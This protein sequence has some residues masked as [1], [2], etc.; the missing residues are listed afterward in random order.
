MGLTTRSCTATLKCDEHV[1]TAA[2]YTNFVSTPKSIQRKSAACSAR[3]GQGYIAQPECI[4]AW[5]GWVASQYYVGSQM[6][7]ADS[8]VINRVGQPN[9]YSC[10]A[11]FYRSGNV[12]AFA[13]SPDGSWVN[14]S[15]L[16]AT[17]NHPANVLVN[18][19]GTLSTLTTSESSGAGTGRSQAGDV[20]PDVYV[21]VA[22]SAQLGA[23]P[24]N[25]YN[26]NGFKVALADPTYAVVNIQME[27]S[28]QLDG[29][30]VVLKST[31]GVWSVLDVGTEFV[32]CDK[33]PPVV[34]AS[35]FP[36]SEGCPTTSQPAQTSVT[37][38][39]SGT[40]PPFKAAPSVVNIG[41]DTHLRGLRWQD[42]GQPTATAVGL[43]LQNDCV[44]DCA[45]GTTK[46]VTV[47]ITVSSIGPCR[48]PANPAI[49]VSTVAQS[50]VYRVLAFKDLPPLSVANGF[51]CSYSATG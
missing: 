26:L 42:W 32:G 3:Y 16:A 33:V 14:T 2:D 10:G 37:M 19:D 1:M 28:C 18:S 9:S 6:G 45:E 23:V 34:Y 51:L 48:A 25:C 8:A 17:G 20:P 31:N 46:W 40:G 29:G 15:T 27:S 50:S 7:T 35:L 49:S 12:V 43:S 5:N 44:P 36:G 47:R 11:F 22:R 24:S 38:P 39:T 4:L 30:T 21:A 41:N 13:Q